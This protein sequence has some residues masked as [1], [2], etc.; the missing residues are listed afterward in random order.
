[1]THYG[2][3]PGL[4][5]AIAN[6]LGR[7][8]A[9]IVVVTQVPGRPQV[10]FGLL[11]LEISYMVMSMNQARQEQPVRLRRRSDLTHLATTSAL[12]VII[13]TIVAVIV[14]IGGSGC[15][16]DLDTTPRTVDEGSFGQVVVTLACQRLAYVED[17]QDGNP[18]VDVAG[19]RYREACRG[20]VATPA[21]AP[22][23]MA[24]LLAER[25]SLVAAVDAAMPAELLPEVQAFLTSDD[26]LARYDDD[27]ATSAIDAV[28][29]FLRLAAG[30]DDTGA[31]VSGAMREALAR[32]S[33]QEGYAPSDALLGILHAVTRYPDLYA[34]S[35]ALGDVL[36]PD[37]R[38]RP[39]LEE[40][41]QS[42]SATLRHAEGRG[43]D[44]SLLSNGQLALTLMLRERDGFASGEAQ[45]RTI[46]L[47]RR[48]PRGVA[49]VQ[50]RADGNLPAPFI[51]ADGDGAA[52]IDEQGAFILSPLAETGAI[53][54]APFALAPD[55]DFAPW[56]FRDA[57]G[58]ALVSAGGA[59]LFQYLNLDRTLLAALMREIGPMVGPD[60]GA[61][62]DV[63][64]GARAL[65]G[66][67][68]MRER[69]YN[70]GEVFRFEGYELA[71]S[72][73]MDMAHGYLQLGRMD[74]VDDTLALATA[75]L[76][77][78][79]PE[80]A[81][82]LEAF[83]RAERL[84]DE[85][86]EAVLADNAPFW[87]EMANVVIA[88][89]IKKD[90]LIEDLMAALEQPEIA[91][92]ALLIGD[93]MRYRDRFSFD[94]ERNVVGDFMTEVDPTAV[95]TR[96]DRSIWQRL[97]H[98]IDDTN[99]ARLCNKQDAVVRVIGIPLFFDEC[100]LFQID[101]LAE[102]FAQ[103]MAYAKDSDG[104]IIF[105]G[106]EPRSGATFE[107]SSFLIDAAPNG[108]V[109]LIIEGGSGIDGFRT[110]PTPEALIRVLFLDPTPSFVA[111]IIDP[112]VSRDVHDVR[113]YHGDTLQVW[114]VR[115]FFDKFRP[116]I[117]AFADH[118][119]EYIFVDFISVL[120][121]HWPSADS[122]DHQ[123]TDRDSADFAWGSGA[124]RYQPFLSEVF[125]RQEFMPAL[126]EGM[127]G[128]NEVEMEGRR[129]T[130][131]VESFVGDLFTPMD[132]LA[133]RDGTTSTQTEDGRDVPV[134][135]P[136]YVLA[137][138]YAS[139]RERL[140]L[141]DGA[142]AGW[143]RAA[144]A[145]ND[146]LFRG[147]FNQT[148]EA[149]EFANPEIV[150]ITTEVIAY[151]R[152][153]LAVHDAAGDRQT[154]L[155]Q[156]LLADL[157]LVIDSPTFA[158]T[159][160]F[161]TALADSEA[162]AELEAF[163]SFLLADQAAEGNFAV[164]LTAAADLLQLIVLDDDNMVPVAHFAGEA[165]R[166]E[167]DY[168]LRPLDFLHDVHRLDTAIA[169]GNAGVLITLAGNFFTPHRSG[170]MPV[171]DIVDG[172]AEVERERPDLERGQRY[173]SGDFRA[174]LG[175][176]A[177]FLDDE[178]RGLRKFI[179]IIK[180]RENR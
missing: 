33:Q 162:A 67:R 6:C 58:H 138:A 32:L 155:E 48:D 64:T 22:L 55:T 57:A 129:A 42:A 150:P 72:P 79:Q 5:R 41:L 18:Q 172:I 126:V 111:N 44:G 103:S 68:R 20:N 35:L 87:D 8:L 9:V 4:S 63:I 160:D 82:L 40:L 45:A 23:S 142:G 164:F 133:K 75:L 29:A 117:Q 88:E 15:A 106:G 170:R 125:A 28:V 53:D 100:G 145:A 89:M 71:A 30:Q 50:P 3:R 180:G 85:F 38:A 37:G 149:W 137:D 7:C 168:V 123:S 98:L 91:E 49:Q 116:I 47:V 174:I 95:D 94:E 151:V 108:L 109:D 62:L 148:T 17:L 136:W 167:R 77:Q 118:D 54:P 131:I 66:P 86:P 154:W 84:G 36:A 107:W 171:S 59:R 96:F 143:D 152:E 128:L 26:F 134:L 92:L 78:R 16:S 176:V 121:R 135:S 99:G 177:E 120:H 97:I 122:P 70:D 39:A 14:S 27:S 25:D 175:S 65:M 21:D 52:D 73:L 81:R 141:V 83:T 13:M 158:A 60:I 132:G 1:M 102:F 179:A 161:M 105:D 139:K 51:D 144:R 163:A 80:V 146:A 46:P 2:P 130:D 115:Q 119:A 153:R 61:G 74:S 56:P 159:M 104:D 110:H 178:K 24:A 124:L 112:V 147:Q 127:P 76:E 34:L 101:N 43:V 169:G 93:Y 90:G 157:T 173:A 69:V 12:M 10:A 166:L 156:Q 113:E 31:Q 140:D 165:L 11:G 114:E 19:A